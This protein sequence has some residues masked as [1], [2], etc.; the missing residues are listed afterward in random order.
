MSRV[1]LLGC[2][3]V[4]LCLQRS[5]RGAET[6]PYALPP[7]AVARLGWSPLRIGGYPLS[8]RGNRCGRELTGKN[9]CSP[10]T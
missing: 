10:L 5:A 8:L 6:D 3:I 7:G 9:S 1:L 2:G 4:F